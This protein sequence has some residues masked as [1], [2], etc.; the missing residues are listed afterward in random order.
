MEDWQEW[1]IRADQIAAQLGQEVAA[2][3]TDF[4]GDGANPNFRSFWPR[5]RT[6]KERVRVAPAI[7]LEDKLNLE[8]S[9]RNLGGRAYKA[10]EAAF[11]V[12]SD[13][14]SELTERLARIQSESERAPAPREIRSLRREL[15]ALRKEFDVDQNL[16]AADRQALWESWRSVNQQVWDLLNTQWSDN[17]AVLRDILV[18]AQQDL[19]RGNPNA[20]RQ[21]VRRFF[22][23][24]RTHEAKQEAVSGL[25]READELRRQADEVEERRQAVRS[26]GPQ[27]PAGNPVEGWRAEV[28]RSREALTRL[29]Q[30]VGALEKQYEE[31]SSVLQQ[32]MVR[33]TL[34]DKRRKVSELERSKRAL[35]QRIEQT[36]ESPLIPTG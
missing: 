4:F 1:Q 32:A 5:F 27:V 6:L 10:Q 17:E 36:E 21:Q 19:E 7:K 28:E 8:R 3:Q 23:A 18:S 15:D 34:V 24:L 11:A 33:G 22:E 14:K 13:R 30:E 25:K 26:P 9:L 12:S 31:S 16:V 20:V 29:E 2:L 35:E